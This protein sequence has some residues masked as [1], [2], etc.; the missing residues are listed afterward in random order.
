LQRIH[1]REISVKH[2]ASKTSRKLSSDLSISYHRANR[3]ERL[4]GSPLKRLSYGR[5][6]RRMVFEVEA[7]PSTNWEGRVKAIQ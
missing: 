3:Y 4:S 1:R 5:T 7:A 6:Y 2:R